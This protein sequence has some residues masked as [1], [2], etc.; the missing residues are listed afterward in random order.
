MFRMQERQAELD[1][2]KEF[3][4]MRRYMTESLKRQTAMANILIEKLV[5]ILLVCHL[6]LVVPEIACIEY[7]SSC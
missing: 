7:S 1:N 4:E 2:K 3:M 5:I 6:W